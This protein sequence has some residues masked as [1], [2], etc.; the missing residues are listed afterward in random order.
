MAARGLTFNGV[1]NGLL[2]DTQLFFGKR[3]NTGEKSKLFKE[4]NSS[5]EQNYLVYLYTVFILCLGF[6]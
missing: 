4:N 2:N 3:I 6:V 5:L 1:R